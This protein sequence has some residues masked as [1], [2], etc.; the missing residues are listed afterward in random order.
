MNNTTNT[1]F[2]LFALLLSL[3]FVNAALPQDTL[4][5]TTETL[6]TTATEDT[7]DTSDDLELTADTTTA[8]TGDSLILTDDDILMVDDGEMAPDS[9]LTDSIPPIEKMPVLKKFIEA[10]YPEEIYKQGIEGTVLMELLLNDSGYVDSISVL[11]GVHPVLDSSAVRAAKKFRFTPA[12]AGGET[13]PVLIQYEY[14]FE[15]R[16]VIEQI[17]EYV[18]FRGTL[19]ERGTKRPIADAM[20]VLTFIDT[21][22]DST[23]PVPFGVYLER[24]GTIEGQYLEENRLVTLTDSLGNFRFFSLPASTVQVTA[25]LPGYEDFNEKEF[26]A[27]ENEMVATYYIRRISYSDYEI[28]VHGRVEKKEVSR[29][30]ITLTEVKRVPGLG[31]DAVK[32][33]QAM[34]GVARPVFG[35]GSIV[36][37]G[38]PTWDSRFYLDGV[39]LPRLYHFGGLKSVYNS[40]ALKAVDFFPGGFS[41]R[42]G[43]GIAGVVEITGRKAKTDRWHGTVDLSVLDGS[44]LVEGPVTE[45]LSLTGSA[46]R[47]FIGD[48]LSWYTEHAENNLPFSI[49]PFYWDY[50][51]RGDYTISKNSH[52]YLTLF[53]GRDSLTFIS[54]AV[55]GG[56]TEISQATNQLG[57][58]QTFHMGIL[59]WDWNIHDRWQNTLRYGLSFDNDRQSAFGLYYSEYHS[60]RNTLR[61]QLTWTAGDNVKLHFGLDVDWLNHDMILIIPKDNGVIQR[62]TSDN[63]TFGDIGAYLNF[64]WM[65]FERLLITPGLRFDYYPELYYDGSVLPELWDYNSATLQRGISGEPSFRLSTRYEFVKDHT[66]KFSAGNYSQTPKP[67][68]QVIHETWGDPA[69]PATK[70]AHYV[71]GHEWQIT[72][73]F[74]SDIQFYLN[75]QWDIPRYAAPEDLDLTNKEQ[76]LWIG[77]GEGRMFGME[78]MLRHDQSE[79]FFG[80]LAYS[81]S[82][83]ERYNRH[84]GAWELFGDDE[85]HNIQVV[86]SWRLRR[87]W[88]I[89]FRGRYVTGKPVTPVIG[90]MEDENGNYIEPIYGLKNSERIGPFFQLDLRVDKKF[91]F[92]TWLFSAY[93][94]IINSNY[95]FYKSPEIEVW[96]EFFDDKTT[97]SN[98]FTPALG[99]RA[100]F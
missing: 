94:D 20:I 93:L 24:L 52:L 91:V 55:Q 54:P 29:R 76:K 21:V 3:A 10:D 61:N 83:T 84:R 56:S 15:L 72:D 96:N 45:K 68:G 86:G 71:I 87:D 80:W 31:G 1:V 13:V 4:S 67:L 78:I 58:K 17:D 100:E 37:R 65:P 69:M 23:L 39:P 81:L 38:A 35:D 33:V 40:D 43:N 28:V 30:H 66:V 32:V 95:F 92:N 53:G 16:E 82:R 7:V 98:I 22:S 62:D 57:I 26:I 46:R 70:A 25:P 6:Q 11:K 50:T 48:I 14:R 97:I 2:F 73:L 42:Y 75:R 63:W 64:E 74:R 85:T 8:V 51:L 18:N 44:F 89:G 88:D 19:I 77:D 99:L 41:T 36:V 9:S 60:L 59:G 79:R 27:P 5:T 12:V 49:T 34:P 47:S 90:S